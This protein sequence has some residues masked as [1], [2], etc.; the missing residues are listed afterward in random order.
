MS[1]YVPTYLYIK[2]HSITGLKYFGKTTKDPYKYIGSGKHWKRHI[3]NHGK[4][5]IETL[6]FQLFLDIESL[7]DYALKFSLENN[8]VESSA[9]ANLIPENGLD[10][11]V[12]GQKQSPETKEKIST[13]HTGKK[14]SSETIAKISASLTGKKRS[15][16]H[17]AK[18]IGRKHSAETV[19]KMSASHTGKKKSIIEC[20]YCNKS[21]GRNA[22]TRYHFNNCKLKPLRFG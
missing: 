21:G 4:E 12:V 5:Y 22:M 13:A 16:E 14:Q 6:W 2:Q 3:K 10:G 15:P 20:P 18:M 9:W 17:A 11:G 7:M 8:I 1:I 19:A